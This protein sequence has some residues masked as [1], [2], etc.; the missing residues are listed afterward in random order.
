MN[1]TRLSAALFV[2]F[3]SIGL[4]APSGAATFYYDGY[5][6]F[7]D[8]TG[9]PGA[10]NPDVTDDADTATGG[11]FDVEADADARNPAGV[12]VDVAWGTA[13]GSE[14]PYGGRSGMSLSRIDD[15]SIDSDAGLADLGILTHFNEPINSG[16]GLE[17]IEMEWTLALF[18]NLTD[19][20]NAESSNNANSIAEIQQDFTLYNWE[21]ANAGY[22]ADGYYY[23]TDG[24]ATWVGNEATG[25][26]GVS[27]PNSRPDGTLVSPV[28]SP[29]P[30][31]IFVADGT[32]NSSNPLWNGECSD[33]HTFLPTE[34]TPSVFTYDDGTGPRDY[35][36]S[37]RGFYRNGDLTDTFW[38]CEDET[39]QGTV[40]FDIQ[41]TTPS[42]IPTLSQWSLILMSLL[43]VG[44]GW[45]AMRRREDNWTA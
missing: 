5:G 31:E 35:S 13:A 38:A 24:G 4:A 40:R 39:C 41:D 28:S 3:V 44:L 30:G 22:G 36:V 34:L 23:S 25:A 8:G 6:G 42:T 9:A 16:T 14:G 45:A 12:G 20:Q 11:T 15:G 10:A 32:D 26:G 29:A 17:S 7:N 33:A 1:R 18:G 37:L 21:T 2:G 43:T 27:C 19:A